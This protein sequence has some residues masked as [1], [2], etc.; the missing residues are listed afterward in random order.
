MMRAEPQLKP[1]GLIS[2]VAARI[3]MTFSCFPLF[4]QLKS[5]EE[6]EKTLPALTDTLGT[7]LSL[8]GEN[9]FTLKGGGNVELL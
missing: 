8:K 5:K 7:W 3:L 2:E 1:R 9:L 6:G 4:F